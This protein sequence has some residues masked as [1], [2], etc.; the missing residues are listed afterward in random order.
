MIRAII[1]RAARLD[2]I[3]FLLTN[4][5]PRR[6]ATDFMGWFARIEQPLVYNVSLRIWRLF[7]DLDLS[8]AAESRFT[9]LHAC[10]TRRLRPGARPFV[11][12]PAIVASPCDAIVG[13]C[14]AVT[15][16]HLLQVKGMSYHLA[17][18]VDDE[19]HAASLVGGTYVTLRLTPSMYHRF[20]A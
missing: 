19:A 1:A 9:S 12:D 5:I 16:G 20:H 7:S 4:R 6:L 3:N 18:L 17:E 13:A 11:A 15:D 8:D 10:F 2:Y 14:G